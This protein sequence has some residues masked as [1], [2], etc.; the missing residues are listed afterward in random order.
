MKKLLACLLGA[1][2]CSSVEPTEFHLTHK[3]GKEIASLAELR[4]TKLSANYAVSSVA[5]MATD[6]TGAETY[7]YYGHPDK[8]G[9][10]NYDLFV[11][12]F[13]SAISRE[14]KGEKITVEVIVGNGET[15]TLYKDGTVVLTH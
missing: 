2:G 12:I 15:V 5:V 8:T 11:A 10:F 13:P 9:S 4:D 3:N 14:Q 7:R 6:E 1:V